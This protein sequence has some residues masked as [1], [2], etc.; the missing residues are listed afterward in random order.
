M[1][2]LV[3]SADTCLHR[4]LPE[5]LNESLVPLLFFCHLL[6]KIPLLHSSMQSDQ[7]LTQMSGTQVIIIPQEI[8]ST[9]LKPEGPRCKMLLK[10]FR[11]RNLAKEKF[12]LVQTWTDKPLEDSCPKEVIQDICNYT[13]SPC[14]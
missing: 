1:L 10:M 8:L 2:L 14:F 3:P 11:K 9:V 7:S 12:H 5:Y 6:R 4:L 13:I